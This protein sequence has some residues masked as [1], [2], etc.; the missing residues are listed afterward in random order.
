MKR[1]LFIL[2]AFSCFYSE[3]Q[4]LSSVITELTS[5][6]ETKDLDKTMLCTI[7]VMEKGKVELPRQALIVPL[8]EKERKKIG[9]D[10]ILIALL[11]DDFRLPENTP[12]E[13]ELTEGGYCTKKDTQ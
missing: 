1:I 13:F 9:T 7:F 3:A 10:R 8:Q 5:H 11:M 6:K 4:L 12:I 2:F